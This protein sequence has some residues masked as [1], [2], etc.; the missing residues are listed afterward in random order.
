MNV[1]I[2][3][4]LCKLGFCVLNLQM[5]ITSSS[6]FHNLSNELKIIWLGQGFSIQT[7]SPKKWNSFKISIISTPKCKCNLKVLE[8]LPMFFLVEFYH[9]ATKKGVVT[10]TKWVL[11]GWGGSPKFATFWEDKKEKS[12]HLNYRFMQV[13]IHSL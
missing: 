9:L 13:T 3:G 8:S 12:S 6:P 11:G 10:S 1:W 2:N 5:D 7:L 4:F